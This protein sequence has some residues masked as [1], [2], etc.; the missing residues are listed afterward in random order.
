MSLHKR[1]GPAI[2]AFLCAI[3]AILDY[4][5]EFE[6]LQVVVADLKNFTSIIGGFAL[7]LGTYGLIRLHYRNITRKRPEAPYSVLLLAVMALYI[8]LG[9]VYGEQSSEFLWVYKVIYGPL[10]ATTYSLLGFWVCSAAYRAF[11]ARN[12][13]SATLIIMGLI[14]FFG[15]APVAGS[16][17]PIFPAAEAFI[18][19]TVSLAGGRG[20]TLA[21]ATG[22]VAFSFK[23]IIGI[24]RTWMGA[25]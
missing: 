4:F 20:M 13:E 16:I 2:V 3:L 14:A 5:I 25:D 21:L 1:T 15:I 8:L 24:E 23:V 19:D 6:P 17:S 18:M 9:L 22:A 12:L 7:F 11:V 10:T